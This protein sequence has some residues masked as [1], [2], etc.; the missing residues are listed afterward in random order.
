MLFSL[1]RRIP[2]S[3][4]SHRVVEVGW[5][6]RTEHARF[7]WGDP[8]PVMRSD[9]QTN[10]PKG[11]T[12]CPAV[13]DHEARLFHVLCP[14]DLRLKIRIETE[15]AVLVDVDGD[16]SSVVGRALAQL[17][18]LAPRNQW[19]HPDRPILQ[20]KTPYLFVAD[21]PVYMTQLP[22][23]LHY[24]PVQWPGVCIGGRYPIHIWPRPLSWAFEW[25]DL[26][27][28]LVLTSGQPWFYCR[29]ETDNPRQHVRLVEAEFTPE[30]RQYVAGTSNVVEYV[31]GTFG[32][33]E[34]ARQRRPEH[35][36]V[37]VRR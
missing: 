32:L 20:L 36:L 24:R 28:E 34:T 16:E 22:P 1:L 18:V 11:L 31:S 13:L 23:F 26:D 29:F 21:H 9:A 19:P 30:L 12:H 35:L 7:I 8:R 25:Y 4:R 3:L 2:R 5:L 14:F 37:K 17:A 33:F 6:L 10:H 27:K 15:G